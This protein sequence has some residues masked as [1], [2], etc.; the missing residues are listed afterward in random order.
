MKAE[1][2]RNA[3]VGVP[4]VTP[5]VRYVKR[6]LRA[7]LENV[8]RYGDCR[9]L[10]FTGDILDRV[11]GKVI[12][13]RSSRYARRRGELARRAEPNREKRDPS[14][15]RTHIHTHAHRVRLSSFPSNRASE[16]RDCEV[17]AAEFIT[18]RSA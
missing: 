7:L 3:S 17:D 10:S 8:E 2:P 13:R 6:R 18:M 5:R 1:T 4:L 9:E 11:E 15:T 16:W 12:Q 14:S